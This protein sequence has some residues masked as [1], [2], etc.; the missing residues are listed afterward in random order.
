MNIA[1]TFQNEKELIHGWKIKCILVESIQRYIVFMRE[2]ENNAY[3]HC[4]LK[5]NINEQGHTEFQD[6]EDEHKF[7]ELNQKFLTLF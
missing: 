3:E 4:I 7:N 2:T 6:I 5:M 1:V